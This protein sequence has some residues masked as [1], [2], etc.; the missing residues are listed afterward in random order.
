MWN[1]DDNVKFYIVKDAHSIHKH[2][3]LYVMKFNRSRLVFIEP[4]RFGGALFFVPLNLI[5]Q[6]FMIQLNV[7]IQCVCWQSLQC[8]VLLLASVAHRI[9]NN[10]C[11]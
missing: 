11:V 3:Q 8:S 1:D 6:L 4:F 10:V 7:F 5:L 9:A 2:T